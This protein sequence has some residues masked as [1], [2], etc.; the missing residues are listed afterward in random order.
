MTSV[1]CTPFWTHSSAWPPYFTYVSFPLIGTVPSVTLYPTK[2]TTRVAFIYTGVGWAVSVASTSVFLYTKATAEG[3][4]LFVRDLPCVGSCQLLFNKIWG[5][6]NFPVFFFPCLVTVVL[7]VK[8][9]TV[10]N[11]QARLINNMSMSIRS[12]LHVGAS[13]AARTLGVT[14]GVYLLCWLPF[15]IDTMVDSL[16]D[17]ITHPS[18]VWP[19]LV[20][21]LQF[22][23]QSLDLCVF[24]LLVQEKLW[25]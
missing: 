17:F 7:Y 11:K 12:Q 24:L 23:L 13:K 1:G 4:G 25:N 6:L 5:W 19:S 16:L 18:S 2:F 15:T 9:F 14:V 20:C 8:I 3:L 21:L 10:A 22:C